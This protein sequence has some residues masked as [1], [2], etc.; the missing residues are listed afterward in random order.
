VRTREEDARETEKRGGG[1]AA[2]SAPAAVF[3]TGDEP[4][5]ATVAT[6]LASGAAKTMKRNEL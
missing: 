4:T 2:G 1:G 5:T 3:P 6:A